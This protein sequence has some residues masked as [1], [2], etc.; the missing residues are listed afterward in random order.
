VKRWFALVAA[1]WIV[2]VGCGGQDTTE[3]PAELQPFEP[4]VRVR[5]L[6]SSRLGK[7][8]EG[9]R[10]GLQPATDG[11]FIY[12]GT[13]DGRVSAFE[14]ETGRRV[15]EVRTELALAGGPGYGSGLLAFGTSDGELIALDAQTGEE[16]WRQATGSEI[17]APPAVSGTAVIAR[18]VDGRLRGFAIADGSTL[19]TVEQ[20]VPALVLRGTTAP[21]LAGSVVISGFDNGRL[22]AYEVGTG[23]AVWELAIATPTGR[24]E[25]ERLVDLS[26]GLE[27]VGSDVYA[28]GYHGRAMGIALETG[29]VLWQ[30][31][32]SSYSG[33]GADTAN[34]YVT[35]EW[36]SVIAL[37][38]R[39]GAPVWRQEA[40]RLRDVTA[41]TRYRDTVVVGDFEGYLHWLDPADGRFLARERAGQLRITGAPLVVG[42]NL[43]VQSDDGRVSAF[44][45]VED[46]E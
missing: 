15:F 12:A 18:S 17:L 4:S 19:W 40:L 42:P 45:L 26:A 23:N 44:T 30:Q 7:G 1:T 24:T 20:S 29:L 13:H 3:P 14:A 10:L 9:L 22:G 2:A 8:A 36:G 25:L 16:R 33:L 5:E 46:A 27:V 28:A 38:R 32:L 39:R 43:F 34:V 21:Y 41:P 6:W 37:D 11:T 35:D 31:E